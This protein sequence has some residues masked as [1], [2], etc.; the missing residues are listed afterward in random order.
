M[1]SSYY[2]IFRPIGD[3]PLFVVPYHEVC[4]WTDIGYIAKESLV[5]RKPK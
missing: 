4:F 2:T 3:T 5:L 1:N